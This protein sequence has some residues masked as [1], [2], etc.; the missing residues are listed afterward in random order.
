MRRNAER[1]TLIII[2]E[3]RET[4]STQTHNAD[5]SRQRLRENTGNIYRANRGANEAN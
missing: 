5:K 1:K 4:P 3:T 2:Q